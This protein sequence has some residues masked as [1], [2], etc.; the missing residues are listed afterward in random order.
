MA[1]KPKPKL[2]PKPDLTRTQTER[3]TTVVGV[4]VNFKGIGQLVPEG[5]FGVTLTGVTAKKTAKNDDMITFKA[6]IR[7][8]AHPDLNGRAIFRNYVLPTV[9][10]DEEKMRN[11]L[12]Y[13]Q[14]ALLAFGAD[15]DD[16]TGDEDFDVFEFAKTLNGNAARAKVVHKP[17]SRKGMEDKMQL[18]VT[19]EPSNDF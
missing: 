19:F 2:E 11:S 1:R 15:E 4:V 12:Y 3:G 17:D 6:T 16:V 10:G 14:L 18:E 8:D 9:T 7:D 13:F 5:N